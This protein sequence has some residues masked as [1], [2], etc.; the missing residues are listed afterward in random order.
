[1]AKQEA[2]L[3]NE[4]L[5]DSLDSV[6]ALIKKHEDFEKSLA[7]QE[8]KIKA[9]DEFATKLVEG[10]HYA[11]DDVSLR[12]GSLIERRNALLDRS[13]LRRTTLENSYKLQQFE[14]DCDETKGWVLEK[15]KT[16]SDESYLDPTNLNGKLQKHQ[17]FEQELQANK[18][19]IDDV[20][21]NAT[22]LIEESHYAS[23]R[24]SERVNEICEL[25]Q[26]LVEATERKGSK[27]AEA[28]A[29]QQFN[30]GV[31]DLELWL[32]EVEGQLLSEDYGKDLTSVQNLIKKQALL[33]ADVAAHKDRVEGTVMQANGFI[34]K[35]HFDAANIQNKQQSLIGRYEA[36]LNP[37]NARRLRLNDSLR[38]QQLFRDIEDEDSWIREKEPIAAS[39]NRGRDLIGVQ[40]LI[41]KHQAV[42]AEINNH[43]HRI[44][45]VC[46]TG[47]EMINENHFASEEIRSRL[48]ALDDK[49][50]ALKEKANQRKVDLD[51][52][53]QAHQYFADANEA[54]SWMKEKEPIVASRDYGKDEDSTEALLKKHEALYSDLEAFNN[55]ITGLR[56]Q[57]A[58]C[59]QQETPVVDQAGKEFVV[60][61]YDYSEKSPREVSMK[62][63]D[64]L[65]LLNSNNKDWWKV[66]VNDRQGFVP[67][68]YVK[69]VDAGLSASQQHLADQNSIINRQNQIE[70]QYDDLLGSGRERKKKLEESCRAY[71]LVREAAEI[72]QW[73]KDKEQVAQVNEV[74]DD[75]E[76]V[77]VYQKKF[78][79]FMTDLKSNE[80]RLAEM[81]DMATQLSN[82]G[83]TEA[84]VKINQQIDDLN[85]KWTS[86]Q[87]V[88]Q[89]RADQLGSAHEVQR[90]H[91]DID[92]TK[93]WI[94][95]K[96]EALNN[97]DYGRDLRS[98]QTLQR[99][100]DGLERDLAALGDKIRSLDE[101]AQRLIK[102]HPDSAELT[103]S[104]QS[105][106][107]DSWNQL[108]SKANARKEKLLDSF[109]LQRFLADYRDLMSWIASMMS[110]V[111]SEELATDVT[112]AEALLERHQ[113]HRTEIDARFGTFQAF[114]TF[115]EHLLKTGH[116][117][118]QEIQ[119]KL[120]KILE[121][122]QDL[123]QAWI[124]RR[125]KLD[126]CL[127]LQLFY[128]DC[129]QAENWMA[130]REAF[131]SSEDM[132]GEN[133]EALIKKH[134]DFD[135]AISAQE[136]KI[137]FLSTLAEQLS[138]S[139]HYAAKEITDKKNQV[140]E[141]WQHLKEALIDKRS[142][143]GESQTLQQFSRD[144]DEIEN[145]IG[146]K[147]QTALDESYKD[148]ANI[149]S[150]H[151]KHQAFEAELAANADRIDSVVDM[152]K[153][154]IDKRQCA[155]SE[156]AVEQRLV[157]ISEQ[158]R[159]LSHKTTEKSL[160]LKEANK[161]RTF[162][163]AAND[164]GFWLGEIE[165]LLK[166]EDSGKDLASV[167][168]LAK[169]HQLVEADI[170]AHDDRINDMNALADSLIESG[171]F[172]SATI[173]EKRASIN[174]RY[175]RIK[176]LAA[177][178][179]QRLNE[180]HTMHQFFRDIADEE[181]WIKEKKLLVSSDDYGRDLTGVQNLK[182]KHKR[183]EAELNSH[184]PSIQAVQEAG[185]KLMSE[186][187]L[188]VPEIEQ[189]LQ[190]LE[191]NW[192]DLKRMSS[193]RGSKLEES[194]VFQQ[195]L[196]K[197]EEEEAWISEKQQLLS[198]EDYGDTMAAVQGLLKKH[199]AFE[200][201]FAVHRERC[202]DIINA[203]KQ[204]LSEGNHHKEAIE[205]RLSQ[206][207]SRIDSL[208]AS[209]KRRK[210]KLLDNSAY[211]QFMWKADV[212][213]SWIADKE[214]QVR[215]EDYGRDL[216]SVQTL[217]TKQETFDAGLAA[218]EQE[219]IH[220]ITQL[221]D[222]L[223]AA[224]HVQSDAILKRHDDVTTRWRNMLAAS[225]ARKQRLFRMQEQF[226]QIEEL[227]LNFAKKASA[228]NSWFENAEE[229]LT[230][231]VRCNSIEEIRALKEAHTRFQ[232]S[233]SSAQAD[234]RHLAELDHQIKSFN[235]GAN[236]YTWFTMEAL[237]DTWRNLQKI[238]TE[239]DV[240]LN[241]ESLRQEEN[242]RLRREFAKHSNQFHSW[243]TETRMWL[244][245]GSAMMEGTGT[246]EAQLEA[247]RRKA[248]EIRSKKQE[249]KD[250]EDLGAEL[251]EHLILD[252]RYT[253]HGTVGLAQQWD[254]LDQL[255]MR[256]Q[257]N[258]EQQ[259]QARNQSGVSED[260][261]KEFSMMFK[262]FDKD[263]SGRLFKNDFKSCLRALGYDL[264]MVERARKI[265]NSRPFWPS[266]TPTATALSEEV[267]NAFRAI[268][269]NEHPYV[270]SDELYQNLTK[271]MAEYCMRRMDKYIDPQTGK[272]KVNAYDYVEF[273]R[274]LF[275]N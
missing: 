205:Q 1:M 156:D 122:R 240:E 18:S 12:R 259:I 45:S 36:L 150:K 41:K 2:F 196:A 24:V 44:R 241:K 155:G 202:A 193:Q 175:E 46:T 93:D 172:D 270:T 151:Q 260:A 40:N 159:H 81:N 114:D 125:L 136:E 100:H 195:F 68:A 82:L 271:D 16:A 162:N 25:W 263:K 103:F 35:G 127:E 216:S 208:D 75:L 168:N 212:V 89:Q 129:E 66:E 206:L 164:L 180:A 154:L 265:P 181:S 139:G 217:L 6:E 184:E 148:P 110:L 62:K 262:H 171:Q 123:E 11:A 126:H 189:R 52:S 182:K 138:V 99:K 229:D 32:D 144:A 140:L 236:P 3:A 248:S 250:I 149:Q 77:E 92:E 27:L 173:Q 244:L 266:L 246:L 227:F 233:L 47:D 42:L 213:E 91:R 4:D 226:R 169:K 79:D 204:L 274:T 252:N 207:Q 186:S 49:W 249:L 177:Y 170:G 57:A 197:V 253:E 53:L 257:H 242:D 56:D 238:I 118:S 269:S 145:W 130:S 221:K 43:E 71:Q 80:V 70:H 97:D 39:T 14:R 63:G 50:N 258:L 128:R 167:Q 223:L 199:D 161:Q 69:R 247:T 54:E 102:S 5:G 23:P 194:H 9:L 87:A 90:F 203:G 261:L 200:A 234:F 179:R 268:A 237:E 83:Q 158:W 104:K 26:S 228:F 142:K 94:Q 215:S 106:I 78:D 153:K 188:G 72:S 235:V 21:K 120:E 22:E 31:E 74:G 30:R 275:Q 254:Q 107:N 117:A 98:V 192:H 33:E 198:V 264:P 108:T 7:A 51:D 65:T 267:E 13:G 116:Y 113:E 239:R 256:M 34:E 214:V 211:L 190:A 222:Q 210:N 178:R 29:Q 28:L 86:L 160:K 84:A 60:A 101:T 109:D 176:T 225:D 88:T 165:S 133:V 185:Q 15:L 147:L 61:L 20:T 131:L 19:R 255:S 273:T 134:E 191:Q 157:S 85:Q 8:E 58:A 38:V 183:L 119:E 141:R 67:A 230:D 105:E 115:G 73:I 135:K 166:S 112:G 59:K 37:M 64:V 143:L 121:S 48:L 251:E 243:L 95:E 232:E 272:E 187:N 17:N 111:S 137:S 96:D 174:E 124:N 245:D 152:G 132:G 146:E 231:P 224:S 218:F 220:S 201:D 163:A 209:A 55:T 219:G 10:Q 76:Q